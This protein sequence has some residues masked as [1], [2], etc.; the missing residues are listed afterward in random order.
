MSLPAPLARIFQKPRPATQSGEAGTHAWLLH[1][2]PAEK[3]RLDP[4]MGW[5]GSGD[6]MKQVT[7]EFPSK[8][9]AIAYCEARGLSFEVEPTPAPP[10]LKPKVYAD[11]FRYGRPENWTH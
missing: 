1:F 10:K 7:L 6:T 4:L 5:A 3:L 9:A 2:A 11:N 8:E